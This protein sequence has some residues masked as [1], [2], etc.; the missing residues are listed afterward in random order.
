MAASVDISTPTEHASQAQ[1]VQDLMQKLD[2]LFEQHL[3]TLDQYQKA[4]Q[5][6]SLHLSSGF[7]SLTQANFF[8][9]G[10]RYGQDYYDERMQAQ[11]IMRISSSANDTDALE[12]VCEKIKDEPQEAAAA[13]DLDGTGATTEKVN[14]VRKDPL[15]WFGVLVPP[16]LRSAQASFTLAA[17][18][19]VPNLVMLQRKLRSLEIEIGRTRKS[20]KKLCKV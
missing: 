20:I 18:G 4:R 1:T 2:D 16:A 11:Q 13:E 6:L 8:N 5:E 9:K 14:S 10:R 19:S 17:E 15:R 7:M 12:F 3:N